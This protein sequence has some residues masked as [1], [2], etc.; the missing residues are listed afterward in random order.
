VSGEGPRPEGGPGADGGPRPVPQLE[1]I[2]PYVMGK[3]PAADEPRGAKLSSNENPFGPSP[4]GIA[5]AV[6][7]LP[8]VNRYP[9]DP[10]ALRV[11]IAMHHGVEPANVVTG[12]G[13]DE[14]I[15]LVC[16]VYLEPGRRMVVAS[17]PY[18]IHRI[19]GQ[20]SGAELVRVPVVDW[21]HD[22]PGMAAAARPGDVVAVTNPHNPTGT[23]VRPDDLRAFLAAVPRD[24]VV[25]VDEAYHE[26]MDDEVRVSAIGMLDLHPGLIISRTF[27]KVY[28]LAGL[29]AG[30]GIGRPETLEPLDRVRAPANVNAIAL[31]GAAAAL[32]D[33]DHVE[34]TVAL[35]RE[36]RKRLV[37]ACLRL[38]LEHVPSQANFVLVRDRDGWPEALGRDGIAVRPGTNLGVPGWHRVTIGTPAEMDRVIGILDLLFG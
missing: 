1:A 16:A 18:G 36:G 35:T 6:A 37:D 13:S 5:A 30:Y 24:C 22:L 11:R 4:L 31:A 28:G 10:S 29:R 23:A 38:G 15:H 19:A 32:D 34:R 33:R 26:Y 7:A 20:L 2:A 27:S 17:P 8:G 21:V 12:A 3:P 9:D 25:L 14:V